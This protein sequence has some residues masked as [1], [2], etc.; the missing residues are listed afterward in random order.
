MVAGAQ[1][2]NGG[3]VAFGRKK[4]GLRDIGMKK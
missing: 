3:S 1:K 2:K 4:E